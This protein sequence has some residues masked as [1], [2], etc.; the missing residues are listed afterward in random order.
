LDRS[1]WRSA[2][3]CFGTSASSPSRTQPRGARCDGRCA[4]QAGDRLRDMSLPDSDLRLG[5]IAVH[6]EDGRG[7]TVRLSV[8]HSLD[9]ASQH[10]FAKHGIDDAFDVTCGRCSLRTPRVREWSRCSSDKRS[11]TGILAGGGGNRRGCWGVQGFGRSGVQGLGVGGSDGCGARRDASTV[12]LD[13][14]HAAHR[15]PRTTHAVSP[16]ASLGSSCDPVSV[17]GRGTRSWC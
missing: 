17:P 1:D 9:V 10:G 11:F 7:H 15:A 3:R 13:R 2:A 16:S 12:P 8:F 14:H 6:D 5:V 4:G